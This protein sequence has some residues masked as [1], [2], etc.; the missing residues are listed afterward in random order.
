MI[1][2][3]NINFATETVGCSFI[4]LIFIFYILTALTP[5]HNMVNGFLELAMHPAPWLCA[6]FEDFVIVVVALI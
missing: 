4:P 1:L 6:I 2:C 3:Y 5:C